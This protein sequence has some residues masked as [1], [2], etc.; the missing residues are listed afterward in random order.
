VPFGKASFGADKLR[1]N[2]SAV[3]EA[4]VKVKPASA[5]GNYLKKVSISTTMGPGIK[6]DTGAFTA[7]AS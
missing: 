6:V 7:T 4:I 1:E 3:L 5:K 2:L